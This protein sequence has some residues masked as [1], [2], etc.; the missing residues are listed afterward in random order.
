MRNAQEQEDFLNRGRFAEG[1]SSQ[2][3]KL[4]ITGFAFIALG[5]LLAGATVV[6]KIG[7]DDGGPYF[8]MGFFVSLIAG[9][10]CFLWALAQKIVRSLRH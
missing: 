3:S 8:V 2:I 10:G 9:F 4:V 1:N 6:F 7:R 5:L